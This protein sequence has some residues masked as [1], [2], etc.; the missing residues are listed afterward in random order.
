MKHLSGLAEQ[1]ILATVVDT[2]NI[3]HAFKSISLSQ[4]WLSQ[5]WLIHKQQHKLESHD[6]CYME[7]ATNNLKINILRQ[8]ACMHYRTLWH[9]LELCIVWEKQG[10]PGHC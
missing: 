5:L 3:I 9:T 2:T 1:A 10:S 8:P 7:R 4:L 6:Y